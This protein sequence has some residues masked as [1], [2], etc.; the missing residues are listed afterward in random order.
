[1]SNDRDTALARLLD[2]T[3][4]ARVIPQLP[5]E[6]LH[7]LVLHRGLE[8]CGELVTLATP[9]QL[10]SLLD[11]DL[12]SHQPGRDETFDVDRFGDW[13]EVLVDTGDAV[14]ARTVASLD[15]NLVVAGLSRYVRVFDPGIFE[16]VAQSDDEAPDRRESMHEGGAGDSLECEV[17]GYI[18]RAR[19]TDAW[20][21]IIALLVALE[22]GHGDYFQSVMQGCRQLSNSR[23]EMSG[24]DDL[25]QDPE[26]QLHD[27]AIEREQRQSQRGYATAAEARAFLEMAR[28]PGHQGP[29]T[30]NPIVAAYFRA[31]DSNGGESRAGLEPRAPGDAAEFTRARELAFLANTLLVGSSIQSRPF[32]PGEASEAATAVCKLGR[33]C[34]PGEF[35]EGEGFSPR[36]SLIT[37]FEAGWSLLHRDVRQFA[38]QA[39]ATLGGIDTIELLDTTAWVAAR[40]LLDDCPVI[41]DALTAILEGRT[42]AVSPTE[43]AFIS[44]T[45]QIDDVRK[46]AQKLPELLSR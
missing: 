21:A 11:L 9:A 4:L 46:F 26:Q 12:W 36:L 16:P 15:R 1:M 39:I 45:S 13:L 22:A 10:T 18:V 3:S 24:M 2:T 38:E 29:G 25:L 34:I 14:A 37:A 6:T 33:E 32:T 40:G 5:P 30:I 31:V 19:R 43:F 28:Q 35:P 44:T 7:Q 23:P 41:S 27:V 20:D 42:T 17:C 8:A